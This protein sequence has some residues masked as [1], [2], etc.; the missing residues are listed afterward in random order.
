[1]Q[2]LK[3]RRRIELERGS[4][5]GDLAT[6]FTDIR[7]RT[8]QHSIDI[9]TA[10]STLDSNAKALDTINGRMLAAVGAS[11]MRW[12]QTESYHRSTIS[13][14]EQNTAN[15]RSVTS[16][17]DELKASSTVYW[18]EN[19]VS[20]QEIGLTLAEIE[21]KII[22]VR[23][24]STSQSNRMHAALQQLY[25]GRS[26]YSHH[27][28]VISR[29]IETH[30]EGENGKATNCMS[31]SSISKRI[32]R[33]CQLAGGKSTAVFSGEAQEVI[34][35]LEKILDFLS[36]TASNTKV[37]AK[38]PHQNH[39]DELRDLKRMKGMLMSSCS[40]SVRNAGCASPA[41]D[42]RKFADNCS[43]RDHNDYAL[44]GRGRLEQS[45]AIQRVRNPE[46]DYRRSI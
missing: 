29:R 18:G 43:S 37:M 24:M 23:N 10:N 22:E 26:T 46:R 20:L 2:V 30:K 7:A 25:E 19:R 33:L 31:G 4:A 36:E 21:R 14:L 16:N 5:I 34:E 27:P 44:A 3:S 40:V 11:E 12:N 9:N 8:V 1:M 32:K 13:S 35:D 6:N 41:F 17:L 42:I 45:D 39:D 38:R 15:L 28:P